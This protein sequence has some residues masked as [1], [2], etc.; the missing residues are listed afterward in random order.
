[1]EAPATLDPPFEL[2]VTGQVEE[3]SLFGPHLRLIATC[4]TVP[5]SNKLVIHDVVENCAAQ[6]AEVQM[7]YHLNVGPP[8]LEAGSRAVAPVH[9]LAPLPSLPPP[10]RPPPPP[11]PPK[12]STPMTPMPAR[13]L[14]SQSRSTSTTCSRTPP[15]GRWRCSTTPPPTV[16]SPC[17]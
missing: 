8:F 6:P 16:V 11:A 4:T 14:P 13:R 3:A 2:S 17:A 10:L 12:A 15:D 5:G 7:L 1:V 9:Q